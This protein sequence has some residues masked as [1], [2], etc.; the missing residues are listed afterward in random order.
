MNLHSS[1]SDFEGDV[2]LIDD[3][4]RTTER[5]A[6]MLLNVFRDII[7]LEVIN[8]KTKYM[9]EVCCRGMMGNEHIIDNNS[10]QKVTTFIETTE[11]Y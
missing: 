11:F 5:N 10:Y 7:G 2:N 1:G 3:D 6:G 8:R 9:E 4:I